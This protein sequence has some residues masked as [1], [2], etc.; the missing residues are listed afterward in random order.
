[1][2]VTDVAAETER[3]L[4]GANRAWIVPG[5]PPNFPKGVKSVSLTELIVGAMK[6]V[7]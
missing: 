1:V 4:E 2:P 5:Q 3:S 7:Q 6:D